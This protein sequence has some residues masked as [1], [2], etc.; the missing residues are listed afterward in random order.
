M[1]PLCF[2]I[3][4][5]ANESLATSLGVPDD[6]RRSCSTGT[7]G[8]G[9][10]TNGNSLLPMSTGVFSVLHTQHVNSLMC[11]FSAVLIAPMHLSWYMCPQ[12]IAVSKSCN[13]AYASRPVCVR[14]VR[15]CVAGKATT[16]RLCCSAAVPTVN[17]SGCGPSTSKPDDRCNTQR[18]S[19][20]AVCD[21]PWNPSAPSRAGNSHQA[22][23]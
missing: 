2:K 22:P 10:N 7:W 1:G 20:Q 6:A 18:Q 12:T 4:L 16:R 8:L 17:S 23:L 5:C 3:K 11:F 19:R 14:S 13:V 9:D 15:G 21:P